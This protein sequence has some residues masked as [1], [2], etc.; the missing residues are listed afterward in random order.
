MERDCYGVDCS[1][2]S[3]YEVVGYSWAMS[4]KFQSLEEVVSWVGQ[5]SERQSR[6]LK[7]Q[8]KSWLITSPSV[9]KDSTKELQLYV[10]RDFIET[11]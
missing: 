7:M 4:R 5:V 6:M 10:Y 1:G 3:I 11:N 2:N 9:S 8:R